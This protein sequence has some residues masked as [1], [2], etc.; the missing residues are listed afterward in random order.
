MNIRVGQRLESRAQGPSL[1]RRREQDLRRLASEALSS[2]TA[3]CLLDASEVWPQRLRI[4]A[5][6]F[7]NL[8]LV[9]MFGPA[10]TE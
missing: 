10:R 8:G 4:V 6:D 3:V 2:A 9:L 5:V 1:Q 7:A